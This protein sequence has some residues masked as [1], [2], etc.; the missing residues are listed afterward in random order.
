MKPRGYTSVHRTALKSNARASAPVASVKPPSFE[1]CYSTS[2]LPHE[3]V[4]DLAD[5]FEEDL[6]RELTSRDPTGQ[7]SQ[8]IEFAYELARCPT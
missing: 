4:A 3:V 6:R 1:N 2:F 7:L 8:T 5:D